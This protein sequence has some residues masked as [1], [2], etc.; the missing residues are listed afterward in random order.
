MTVMENGSSV[1]NRADDMPG[2]S[3]PDKRINPVYR[4]SFSILP[5]MEIDY[6][7]LHMRNY[8]WLLLNYLN[9]RYLFAL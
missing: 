1:E 8:S 7:E 3:T 2:E 9:R 4:S 5:S 6:R